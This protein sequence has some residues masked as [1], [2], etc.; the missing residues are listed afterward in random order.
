MEG[1]CQVVLSGRVLIQRE[2]LAAARL[3]DPLPAIS[4]LPAIS[5]PPPSL[6]GAFPKRHSDHFNGLIKLTASPEKKVL[7]HRRRRGG[8]DVE[9]C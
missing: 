9:T 1:R 6:S 3:Y 4:R 7:S 8:S 5:H 2:T